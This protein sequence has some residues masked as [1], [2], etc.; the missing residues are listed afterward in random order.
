MSVFDIFKRKEAKNSVAEE[1]QRINEAKPIPPLSQRD[2]KSL[3]EQDEKVHQWLRFVKAECL[4][5]GDEYLKQALAR[6]LTE[7]FAGTTS[8]NVLEEL[9]STEGV[10]DDVLADA[11]VL[12]AARADGTNHD[13]NGIKPSIIGVGY[14][15]N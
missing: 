14:A 5:R 9:G 8:V 3:A 10:S 1:I 11:L 4:D 7:Q 12:A 2:R 15:R 13:L 6:P